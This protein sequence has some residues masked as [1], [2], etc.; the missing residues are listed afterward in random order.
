[1]LLVVVGLR[2]ALLS[3]TDIMV[4]VFVEV[5]GI[6]GLRPK[7]HRRSPSSTTTQH[8]STTLEYTQPDLEVKPTSEELGFFRATSCR[9]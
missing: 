1:M 2:W 9:T 4:G 7:T 3:C 8:A 6:V 5:W